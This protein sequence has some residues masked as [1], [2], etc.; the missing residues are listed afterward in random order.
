MTEL[1]RH[2]A[3]F[4]V[5]SGYSDGVRT[6]T[7]RELARGEFRT[8]AL[9]YDAQGVWFYVMAS[10]DEIRAVRAWQADGLIIAED[11]VTG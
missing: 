5:L 8:V 9:T 6:I 11:E 3:Q 2:D 7:P 10:K 4:V 1:E